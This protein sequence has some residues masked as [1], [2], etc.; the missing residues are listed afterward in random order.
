MKVAFYKKV[1]P[2]PI[3]T[4]L[5]KNKIINYLSAQSLDFEEWEVLNFLKVNKL[6]VFPYNFIQKY[7]PSNIQL[8]KDQK[9]ELYFTMWEGKKL[10]YKN[11]SQPQKAKKYFKSL[12]LEQDEASPHCYLTPKFDVEEGDVVLDIGA[13]E[14]NFSLSVIEKAS[15]IYLFEV[16]KEWIN[17]LNAT[18]EPWKDKIEIVQKYVSDVD[19]QTCVKLDTF[20]GENKKINFIKADVEGAEAQVINGASRIMANQKNIKVAICTYH[21]QADAKNLDELLKTKGFVNHFSD[22]YMIFHFGSTNVVEPPYLRKA[23][24][25][26]QKLN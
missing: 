16:E 26:G 9:T 11:G 20:L 7:N 18:F 13:A 6:N 3:R 21:R 5:L 10:F 1:I 19:N 17:A 25:R 8:E 2:K 15:F 22:R 14:G 4:R 24:L 23:V 12:L